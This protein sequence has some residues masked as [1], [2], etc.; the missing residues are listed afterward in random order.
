M[1][2][3]LPRA[4]AAPH[5]GELLAALK[6]SWTDLAVQQDATAQ[7]DC[8]SLR[9]WQQGDQ[10]ESIRL[11]LEPDHLMAMRDF[12]VVNRRNSAAGV[13]LTRIH[14]VDEDRRQ[15]DPSCLSYLNWLREHFRQVNIPWIGETVHWLPVSECERAGI[16]TP[17][18]DM[19]L[20]DDHVVVTSQY[21]YGQLI[22]RTFYAADEDPLMLGEARS[23]LS[24]LCKLVAGGA[25]Q[26]QPAEQPRPY[27]W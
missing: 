23:L 11:M 8:P 14:L 13:R 24:A 25:Y 17:H 9:A 21:E 2:I 7:A 18:D 12:I 16:A 6:L 4:K 15:R 20:Y 22:S 5:I 3:C 19:A 27:P 26:L 10:A 1:S